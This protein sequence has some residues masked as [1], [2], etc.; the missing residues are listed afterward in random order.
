MAK[1]F[2]EYTI[3][4]LRRLG[5][6]FL[7]NGKTPEESAANRES[8]SH[9]MLIT[10]SM[11]IPVDH[12]TFEMFQSE[13]CASNM[14]SKD[15][16]NK[17]VFEH[18]HKKVVLQSIEGGINGEMIRASASDLFKAV[19]ASTN[20]NR[21]SLVSNVEAMVRDVQNTQNRLLSR[22]QLLSQAH[23]ALEIWDL[24]HA[25]GAE[26]GAEVS[27]RDS[28]LAVIENPFYQLVKVNAESGELTFLTGVVHNSQVNHTA[29]VNISVNLGSYAVILD[30]K[31]S[32]INVKPCA[33]NLKVRDYVHPHIGSLGDPCWGNISE[34]VNDAI[35]GMD[36]KR[37]FDLLQSLL[38]TYN[39]ENPYV[40]LNDFA[41]ADRHGTRYD[42]PFSLMYVVKPDNLIES[43]IP[44][45]AVNGVYY[46]KNDNIYDFGVVL[47]TVSTSCEFKVFFRIDLSD[48]DS[49]KGKP[50][51]AGYRT[52]E[53][54]SLNSIEH[55]KDTV[56]YSD[57]EG[58]SDAYYLVETMLDGFIPTKEDQEY[59][60]RK[61]VGIVDG[62]ITSIYPIFKVED[63]DYEWI[64]LIEDGAWKYSLG[65]ALYS[66]TNRMREVYKN[67]LHNDHNTQFNN[68]ALP[69]V[70]NST[71]TFNVSEDL[72]S[73]YSRLYIDTQRL[74]SETAEVSL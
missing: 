19:L 9:L 36:Y 20:G 16:I 12:L 25:V 68:G 52:A 32:R 40:R 27:M 44:V 50:V 55:F 10:G 62:N 8:F 71:I 23:K 31:R 26:N 67:D 59:F 42:S 15:E 72:E 53:L 5:L 61:A 64:E 65:L 73:D 28:L 38:I 11:N 2:K 41:T 43:S 47:R 46:Q 30:L 57:I 37:V 56:L 18:L 22:M 35:R 24:Q 4:D 39:E 1:A 45:I 70:S 6:S 49:P 69:R 74:N 48:T 63:V 17:I 13:S 34:A 54:T 58:E 66:S 60:L 51:A 21:T 3:G 14:V 33:G 7:V 29:G